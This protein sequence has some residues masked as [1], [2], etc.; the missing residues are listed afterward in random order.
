MKQTALQKS[1]ASIFPP[2][3]LLTTPESCLTYGYDN[4]SID[5]LPDAVVMP[6]CHDEIVALVQLANEQQV[7]IVPRGRG[8]GTV[9]GAVPTEGGIVIS[10][11]Q[12][13]EC[14][15]ISPGNRY[16]VVQPGLTNLGL[17]QLLQPHGLFW[18]PD[19]SSSAVCTIGG[20]LAYNSAGPKAVKY[21]TTRENTLGLTAITGDGRTLT[22]GSRTTKSVVGY[23]LTRLLI[24]SEGT[25][26]VITDATLKLTPIPAGKMTM[27]ASYRCLES[28]AK[29]VSAI[30]QQPQTPCA[31]E[32]MDAFSLAAIA[33]YSPL[34]FAPGTEAVLMIEADGMP[35]TLSA[36][37]ASIE[38]AATNPGLTEFK[39]AQTDTEVLELWQL[40]KALSPALRKIAPKKINEDVVVPV[41]QLPELIMGVHR[42]CD[43]YQIKNA[44][45]GHAGNGNI[46][47][48]FLVDPDNAAEMQRAE[49]C[50]EAM[51]DLVLNLNGSI[52]GEHGVGLVKKPFMPKELGETN[53][54]LMQ[55]IKRCFDPNGVLNPGMI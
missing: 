7:P 6:K 42:L 24:G 29:A 31:L 35:D 18:A 9:G 41:E 37:C 53:V 25:L 3:R 40:R 1:L 19:P 38:E 21:G 46:H 26:A 14:L 4:S 12:L 32:F 54:S 55:D 52:S 36:A 15:D 27:Q 44:N 10:F 34:R 11:E 23:D 22:C 8:T 43:E 48:N 39:L 28:A 2:E 17:Q 45:F 47:V 33:D 49:P 16:A 13:A 51:F 5:A 20:N 30:M 50:L